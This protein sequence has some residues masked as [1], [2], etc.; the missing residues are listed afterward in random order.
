MRL[1]RQY[2]RFSTSENGVA[3]LKSSEINNLSS[4]K[5]ALRPEKKINHVGD[6]GERSLPGNGLAAYDFFDFILWHRADQ[7]CFNRCGAN[8]IH[9]DSKG[10]QFPCQDLRETNQCCLG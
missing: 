1:R 9:G 3:P 4:N 2:L 6:I 7:V 8:R 10:C 5:V